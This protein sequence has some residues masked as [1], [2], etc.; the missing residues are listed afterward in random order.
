MIMELL[1]VPSAEEN[2]EVETQEE[3]DEFFKQIM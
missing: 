1:A 2:K 3:E